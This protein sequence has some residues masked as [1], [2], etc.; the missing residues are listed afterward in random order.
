[1]NESPTTQSSAGTAWRRYCELRSP[2]LARLAAERARSLDG[3]S[4]VLWER[5]DDVGNSDLVPAEN[6]EVLAGAGLYGLSAPVAEGGLGLS[7]DDTCEVAEE[8]AGSCATTAF[9]WLQHLRLLGAMLDPGS[10]PTLVSCHRSDVVSGKAKGGVVLTGLMPGPVRLLA[11]RDEQGWA[12]RGQAPWFSGWGAL[13]L[14]VIVARAEDATT[15]SFLVHAQ[16]LEGARLTHLP[17][18]ALRGTRTVRLDFDGLRLPRE[19]LLSQEPP[20][21]TEESPLRLRLNGSLPLGLA[22]R[23]CAMAGPSL[24][25]SELAAARA[26]LREAV[27]MAQVAEARAVASELAVRAAQYLAV[28]RGSRSAVTG[29]TAERLLREASLLLVFGSRPAI[30]DALLARL[31]RSQ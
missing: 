27:T 10:E 9:L 24:L 29:E 28:Q 14:V 21:N 11:T 8:L 25:D 3:A 6:F 2:A 4:R 17:L 13:D 12:I 23:C 15:V 22:R 19:S 30:R 18:S 20:G 7:Y 16:L 31:G 1:M 26:N 5:C